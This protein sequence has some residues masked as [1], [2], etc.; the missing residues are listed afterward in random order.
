MVQGWGCIA[1][2]KAKYL[3]LIYMAILFD[4]SI[5]FFKITAEDSER[6]KRETGKEICSQFLQ[7]G[8]IV[9]TGS[10]EFL[11]KY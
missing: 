7:G 10:A 2:I 5:I 9:I 1:N 3:T 4:L 8:A 6:E 11:R